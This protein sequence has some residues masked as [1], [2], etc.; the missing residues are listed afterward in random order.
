[1]KI[2]TPRN[3]GIAFGVL[4]GLFI[5]VFWEFNFTKGWGELVTISFIFL[6]PLVIGYIR[7]Y[8]ECKVQPDL[9]YGKMI[10]LS[11]Q[12]IFIFLLVSFITL[13]EGS[14]CIAM[15]LPA[16]MFFASV[17]GLLAGAT[18]YL[19]QRRRS[20]LM[21]VVALPFIIAPLELSFLDTSNTYT[22]KSKVFINASAEDVWDQL[23]TVSRIDSEELGFSFSFS[24]L[25]GI[26]RPVEAS[27][28]G[29]GVDAIRES[30]WEKG[31]VFKE[32][33]TEWVPNH[34]MSYS[35]DIDPNAIPDKA[36]DQHVKLGGEYFSP[37]TGGYEIVSVSDNETILLLETVVRDNTNF[38]IYSQIWG[39]I[40]FADFHQSLLMV[41]KKRAELT[42]ER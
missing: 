38:G 29:S 22:V 9:T 15:A 26:P 39:E 7:I 35:F 11:W 20:T 24:N 25:I 28:N 6:V 34:K 21:S 16:F 33:I 5:R 41:M 32:K 13:L 12:P 42:A 37:L 18:W 19:I 40:I 2:N 23:S 10:T 3:I 27:M 17:G 36:L 4:Y 30:R 31:V 8:F 1:M 14:I